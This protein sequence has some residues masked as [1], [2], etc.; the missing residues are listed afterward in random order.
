MTARLAG[1]RAGVARSTTVGRFAAAWLA[2]IGASTWIAGPSLAAPAT[3]AADR[4]ATGT[5]VKAFEAV[6]KAVTDSMDRVGAQAATVA[7]FVDGK[8]VHSRGFGWRDEAKRTPTTPDDLMRVASVS[9]PFTSAMVRDLVRAGKLSMDEKAFA[10]LGLLPAADAKPD[11]KPVGAKPD[12]AKP[13]PRLGDI[14]LRML[15]AHKGGWDRATAGDPM[16]K[17]RQIEKSLGLT[18]PA[19]P[20]DVVRYMATQP[21]QFA[22]DEKS[23]YSNFGYCVLGRVI[24]KATGKPYADVLKERIADPLKIAG[25]LKLGHTSSAQRDPR[26]VWYPIP[27]AMFSLDVMD[28][29]GGIIASAPAL[30]RFMQAYWINGEPRKPTDRKQ[31]WTFYGSL[32]GTTAVVVQRA[33]GTDFAIL[34]NG[35][36]DRTFEADTDALKAAVMAALDAVPAAER[37]P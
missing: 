26:E 36:R 14:T 16:F 31:S 2:A 4:P 5:A 1:K 21:L 32:P 9:K 22:P 20:A 28:A 35:R 11:A 13:D 30:G 12:A 25:D 10:Y 18:R 27:D 6:D 3:P 7:V 34:L 19:A 29:H 37:K 17:V 23:V 8:I 15:L 24:E 33:D